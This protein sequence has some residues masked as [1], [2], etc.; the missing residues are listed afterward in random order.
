MGHRAYCH[1]GG[2]GHRFRADLIEFGGLP[3]AHLFVVANNASLNLFGL[4]ELRR[5]EHVIAVE[6]THPVLEEVADFV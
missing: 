2:A 4:D 1:L 5:V 3:R 6:A